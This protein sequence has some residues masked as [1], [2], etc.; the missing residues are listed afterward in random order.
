M[1]PIAPGPSLPSYFQTTGLRASTE[2]ELTTGHPGG[3]ESYFSKGT[4]VVWIEKW[5]DLPEEA[6]GLGGPI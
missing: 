6:G 1:S 4:E 2:V 3:L 5:C